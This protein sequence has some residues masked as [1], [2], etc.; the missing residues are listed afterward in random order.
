M[1]LPGKPGQSLNFDVV[2]GCFRLF[3][4]LWQSSGEKLIAF[5]YQ[6]LL[7]NFGR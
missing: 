7:N 5:D 6:S 1:N 4:V 2:F 3:F